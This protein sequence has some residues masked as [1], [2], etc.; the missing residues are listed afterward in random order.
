[1]SRCQ[2]REFPTQFLIIAQ[3]NAQYKNRIYRIYFVYTYNNT[4]AGEPAT[5]LAAPAPD[6]FIKRLRLLVFLFE[7]L[8]LRLRLWHRLQ[9]AK[10]TGSGSW[11][12]IKFGKIF[13][14]PQT[15]KVKLQKKI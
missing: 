2:S 15:S 7:R 11:L 8:W 4:R 10:K 14:S 9:G 1:M 3:H 6:F 5:F 12:L 13:F